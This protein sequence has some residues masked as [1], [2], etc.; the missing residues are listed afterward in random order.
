MDDN[1]SNFMK[2]YCEALENDNKPDKYEAMG[3]N[4]A[5][6]LRKMKLEQQI[7]A[8]LLF[9]KVCVKGLLEQL[10]EG[11][12][13]LI[14]AITI[15]IMHLNYPMTITL[16]FQENIILLQQLQKVAHLQSLVNY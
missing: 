10:H 9:Q 15:I 6:K 14:L 2:K 3:I 8:E 1:V 12:T 7:H 5:V 16:L 13:L 11:L 4:F